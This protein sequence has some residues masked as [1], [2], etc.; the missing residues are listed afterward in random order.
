MNPSARNAPSRDDNSQRDALGRLV[1]V[2]VSRR[3]YANAAIY[4]A[5]APK[6]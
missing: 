4:D 6:R 1:I 3:F 2:A 5:S